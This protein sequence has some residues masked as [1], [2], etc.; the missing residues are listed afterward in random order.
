MTVCHRAA[1][2]LAL[3][4]ATMGSVRGNGWDLPA[5]LANEQQIPLLPEPARADLS[6]YAVTLDSPSDPG[7]RASGGSGGPM[8]LLEVKRKDGK[9]AT[10]DLIQALHIR[11]QDRGARPPL[12]SVWTKTGANHPVYCRYAYMERIRGYCAVFCEDYEVTE[13]ET[14]RTPAP[15]RV[16]KCAQSH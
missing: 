6:S 4:I 9:F 13:T 14:R 5:L 7:I 1:F 3:L 8:W 16:Y 15:R 12:F 10:R 11:V 2:G